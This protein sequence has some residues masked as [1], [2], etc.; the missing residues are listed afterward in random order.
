MNSARCFARC[1]GLLSGLFLSVSLVVAG[2]VAVPE[3]D[4]KFGA[5][6][7]FGPNASTTFYNAGGSVI[8][9]PTSQQYI[10]VTQ[11]LQLLARTF[12]VGANYYS[13]S[14]G[15]EAGHQNAP[16]RDGDAD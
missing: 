16:A 2:A 10:P 3:V 6:A 15:S 1:A 5:I 14:E 11:N 13:D 9:S 4:S 8:P 7:Q 12:A